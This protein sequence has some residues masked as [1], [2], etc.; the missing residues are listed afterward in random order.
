MS[1]VI[2]EP[3]APPKVHETD[4]RANLT[5]QEQDLYDQVL[6]HLSDPQ[7]AIPG[8]EK[9]ELTEQEKF[10]L[11]RECILRYVAKLAPT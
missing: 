8:V 1:T 9:G 2:S 6:K 7:Y 10:W 11:S 4:P 3:I 5:E